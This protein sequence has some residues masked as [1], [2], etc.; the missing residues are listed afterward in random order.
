MF[1]LEQVCI[2]HSDMKPKGQEFGTAGFLIMCIRFYV[3]TG[4][5]G[6]VKMKDFVGQVCIINWSVMNTFYLMS[7][8]TSRVNYWLGEG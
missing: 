1:W 6:S 2:V 7:D 5:A 3:G 8:E 4:N